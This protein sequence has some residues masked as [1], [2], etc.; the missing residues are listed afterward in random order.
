MKKKLAKSLLS[1]SGALMGIAHRLSW[2]A[3]NLNTKK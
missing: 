3:H 2:T 1:L